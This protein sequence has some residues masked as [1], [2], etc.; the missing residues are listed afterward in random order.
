VASSDLSAPPRGRPYDAVTQLREISACKS[1][2]IKVP[3]TKGVTL[4]VLTH[5]PHP[6]VTRPGNVSAFVL[7][8]AHGSPLGVALSWVVPV[9]GILQRGR[10]YFTSQVTPYWY[11]EYGFEATFLFSCH[12]SGVPGP[13][14]SSSIPWP[15]VVSLPP[16]SL[17]PV[18]IGGS[19]HRCLNLATPQAVNPLTIFLGAP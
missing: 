5:A 7:Y 9:P 12:C 14:A 16:R 2:F 3:S 6:L 17:L 13:E 19:H 10:G 18:G 11:W 15:L 1:S 8:H 4:W